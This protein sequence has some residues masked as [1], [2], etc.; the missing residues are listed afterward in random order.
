MHA[1]LL[2]GLAIGDAYAAG[3]EFQDRDWIRQH[4]DFTRFI[5]MREHI[6]VAPE[7]LAA[8]STHY[9]PWDYTDDT[10]MTIGSIKALCSGQNITEQHLVDCWEAEYREGLQRKGYG[11]NGHGSMA[12]YYEGRLSIAEV[13][14]FQ[15]HRPNPGNA[16][17]MRAIPFGLVKEDLVNQYAAINALAT[18]PN[19]QAVQS[20]QIVAR[21]ARYFL[22]EDGTAEGLIPYC[23]QKIELDEGYQNYLQAVDELPAYEDLSEADFSLLLGPQPIQEPYFL[24]G[25]KGLPSDSKYTAGAVL[26]ILKQSSDAFDALKKSVYL[27]GDVDSL[28]ALT[29][30]I[31]AGRLGVQSLPQYMIEAVEGRDYLKKIAAM[32]GET[33]VRNAEE[34]K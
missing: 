32:W 12:W 16:P 34:M 18:H 9:Q 25:I 26:Y 17:A 31:L 21:A 8:F 28:A 5:N 6:Q 14:D 13:R 19:A 24:P 15:R 7:K 10:E 27:G 11:R 23:L 2:L 22:V 30:G 33:L 1:D 3:L 4:V 20:S 29:T